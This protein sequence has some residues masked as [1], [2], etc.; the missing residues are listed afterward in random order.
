MYK[1]Q[2]DRILLWSILSVCLSVLYAF[3]FMRD[4]EKAAYCLSP[5]IICL[6]VCLLCFFVCLSDCYAFFTCERLWKSC[7]SPIAYHLNVCQVR[8]IC[9]YIFS[10]TCACVYIS[11]HQSLS[12]ALQQPYMCVHHIQQLAS[13]TLVS[14][15]TAVPVHAYTSACINHSRFRG[16]WCVKLPV[17]WQESHIPAS[18]Q[19][20]GCAADG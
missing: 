6:S 7:L 17:T 3:S 18:H 2:T 20:S 1:R 19:H 13:I 16:T 14:A 10:R 8:G 5:K 9:L 4:F 11:L 12:L 15:P